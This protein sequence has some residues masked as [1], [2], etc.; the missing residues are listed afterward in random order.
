MLAAGSATSLRLMGS[1][2]HDDVPAIDGLRIG[3][4]CITNKRLVIALLIF[5]NGPSSHFR[6]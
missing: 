4:P 3:A 6:H 5:Y 2:R 1:G